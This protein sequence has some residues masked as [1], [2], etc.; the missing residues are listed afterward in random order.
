MC[1]LTQNNLS[2]NVTHHGAACAWP[3]K[4]VKYFVE[5]NKTHMENNI[6]HEITWNLK[7]KKKKVI[8]ST[9][10]LDLL[11]GTASEGNVETFFKW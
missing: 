7:K 1:F 4:F 11:P 8:S 2:A 10:R 3:I 5:L 6:L 9:L